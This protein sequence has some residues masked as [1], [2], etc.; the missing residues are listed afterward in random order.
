MATVGIRSGMDIASLSLM[1][2]HSSRAMTLDTY[3]DANKDALTVAAEK[4]G[5]TFKS[6]TTFGSDDVLYMKKE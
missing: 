6:E 5:E 3:G 1:M 4:L 2:G